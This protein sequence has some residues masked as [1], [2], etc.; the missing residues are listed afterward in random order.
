M[1]S[2]AKSIPCFSQLTQDGQPKGMKMRVWSQN[3]DPGERIIQI[4]QYLDAQEQI[5]AREDYQI[6]WK[7]EMVSTSTEMELGSRGGWGTGETIDGQYCQPH[8]EKMTQ[9]DL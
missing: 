6:Y 7:W 9:A 5:S 3:L 2:D 1:H 4:Q 8:Q